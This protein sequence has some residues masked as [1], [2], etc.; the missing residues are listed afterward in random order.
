MGSIIRRATTPYSTHA[1]TRTPQHQAYQHV[2][3]TQN[4]YTTLVHVKRKTIQNIFTHS[5]HTYSTPP[6]SSFF[7][8]SRSMHFSSIH[9]PYTQKLRI[10]QK[11]TTKYIRINLSLIICS[12]KFFVCIFSYILS[13]SP[14]LQIILI[15]V[16]I[17]HAS[18]HLYHV[19]FQRVYSYYL[20]IE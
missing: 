2:A 18:H 15:E 14:T 8:F 9:S 20:V 1:Y 5:Q 16:K 11:S 12:K 13:K 7:S 10:P 6:Y 17:L 3:Q 4:H 19:N